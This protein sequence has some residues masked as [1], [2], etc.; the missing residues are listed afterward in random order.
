MWQAFPVIT[1]LALGANVATA[2]V[3]DLLPQAG[4]VQSDKPE[5]KKV[6]GG[7]IAC[8]VRDQGTY[9]VVSYSVKDIGRPHVAHLSRADSNMIR[10]IERYVDSSTL[11]FA[12]TPVDELLV[13][14]ASG[15][16]CAEYR[17]LNGGCNEGY[18]PVDRLR[19]TA[20]FPG[21]CLNTPRPWLKEDAIGGKVPWSWV[22]DVKP[23][24]PEL[25][26]HLK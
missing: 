15:D 10:A 5:Q 25:Q 17:V 23:R 19:G 22:F 1:I 8:Y 7:G 13:F 26:R 18:D 6:D 20:A 2:R 14:N 4:V 3:D 24:K 11:R 21:G 16:P 12:F 9:G